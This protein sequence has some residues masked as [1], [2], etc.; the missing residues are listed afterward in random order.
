MI[1]FYPGTG[2]L[3]WSLCSLS[4]CLSQVPFKYQ[5]G[6]HSVADV[7]CLLLESPPLLVDD[8]LEL[9]CPGASHM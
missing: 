3:L 1:S 9:D 2:S 4:L 6:I 8:P 5:G 7:V